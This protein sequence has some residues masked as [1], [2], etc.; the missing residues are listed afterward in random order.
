MSEMIRKVGA[1]LLIG[2]AV[3][4]AASEL[5][6]TPKLKAL[7]AERVAAETARA[8]AASDSTLTREQIESRLASARRDRES[9]ERASAYAKDE[10]AL[11][12]AVM[13]AARA[14]GV[15]VEQFAPA[16]LVRIGADATQTAPA[17]DSAAAYTVQ[18]VGEFAG[19]VRFGERLRE[20]PVFLR[21]ASAR[22]GRE[23]HTTEGLMRADMAIE[24]FGF[25]TADAS[26]AAPGSAMP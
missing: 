24:V 5:L 9:I 10:S 3:C 21:V 19:V 18:V 25:S 11:Y 13:D 8:A 22:L 7:Q 6:L 15:R 20:L 14:A 1:E 17:G 23:A 16:Q 4:V 26:H 2:V 12:A